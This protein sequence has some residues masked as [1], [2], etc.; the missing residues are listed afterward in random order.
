MVIPQPISMTATRHRVLVVDPDPAIRTLIVAVLRRD[1]HTADAAATAEQAL[2]LQRSF[3]PAAVVVEPRIAGGEALLDALSR[4]DGGTHPA[5]IVVTT[6]DG[7]D[8]PPSRP[9]VH[10]V[11]HK[12]FRLEELAEALETCWEPN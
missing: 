5:L 10:A 4:V 6:P 11:L 1:G 9:A 8:K 3:H 2:E 7:R 12:P